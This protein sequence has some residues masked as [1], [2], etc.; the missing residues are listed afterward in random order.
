[1]K[2][3][4]PP[5]GPLLLV[6]ISF[7]AHVQ[8]GASDALIQSKN[9]RG[10]GLEMAGGVVR[11]GNEAVVIAATG[12]GSKKGRDAVKSLDDAAQQVNSRLDFSLRLSTFHCCGHNRDVFPRR[13]HAVGKTGDANVNVVFPFYLSSWNDDLH[14]LCVVC[15][16]HRVVQQA[17][18]ADYLW[19]E[20]VGIVS[21][22]NWNKM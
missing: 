21:K 10:S 19:R 20:K 7:N 5:P 3:T 6:E 14:T 16:G 15:V 13:G 1:M 17:D 22:R 4:P 12:Y 11:A 2:Q 9:I 8:P 18:G